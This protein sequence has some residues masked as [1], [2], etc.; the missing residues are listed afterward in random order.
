MPLVGDSTCQYDNLTSGQRRS[1]DR[2]FFLRAVLR[3]NN[4]NVLELL[5][6]TRAP[7]RPKTR[8]NR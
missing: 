5:G 7:P 8:E 4:S 3:A 2:R 1:F 6:K